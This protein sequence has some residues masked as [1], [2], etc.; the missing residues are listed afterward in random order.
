M[1]IKKSGREG[2]STLSKNF[3]LPGW[4][5]YNHAAIPA[6]APHE[7]PDLAPL[8]DGRIWYIGNGRALLARWTEDW[9]CGEET[10][11]WYVIKDAPLDLS[12][13]KAKRRYEITKGERSFE[14][15]RIEPEACADEL[16]RVTVAAYSAWPESY[17]PQED[18]ASFKADL[19][20]W[21]EDVIL[22]AFERESGR[23]AGYAALVEEE[24]NVALSMLRA[25]PAC[26]KAGI[27]AALVAGVLRYYGERLSPRFYLCD[28]ERSVRHETAFQDYLEK[29]F[30]FRK[31]YCRL[32]VRYRPGFGLLVRA[33]YPFRTL[34]RGRTG[35]GGQIAG[36]MK[37][38]QLRRN[39]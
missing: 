18:E 11:W 8:A 19:R 6:C 29:Y 33:L 3:E 30:G 14:V 12:A 17:R 32:H 10:N 38:E 23:L 24:D 4:A 20:S 5:Y 36:V 28:G 15:R 26:E 31:A 21:D 37:M 25:D 16:Y 1:L 34:F 39:K 13:M 27:N 2:E 22:A 9:D 35:L 7:T